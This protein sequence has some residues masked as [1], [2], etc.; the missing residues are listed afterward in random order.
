MV[1]CTIVAA[2]KLRNRGI[3]ARLQVTDLQGVRQA[4]G[5]Y[6][7]TDPGVLCTDTGRFGGAEIGNPGQKFIDWNVSNLESAMSDLAPVPARSMAGRAI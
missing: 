3:G 7:L 1:L 6:M 2:A 5:T 4:D